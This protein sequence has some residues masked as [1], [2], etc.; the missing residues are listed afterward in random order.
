MNQKKILIV[1]RSFYPQISPRSFRTTELAKEFARQG[2]HVSVLTHPNKIEHASFKRDFNIY[3]ISLGSNQN[4]KFQLPGRSRYVTLINRA[5]QRV[6][7]ML[8]EYPDIILMFK[9][10]SALKKL[11]GFDLLISIAVP[12][13]VHWGVA[14]AWNRKK[15][16]AKTW[17]A[18]CGDPYMGSIHDSYRKLFY[19]K[20]FEKW[21]CRKANLIAVP[22]ISMKE[23]F[24]PEFRDKI[25]EIPQGFKF[26]DVRIYEGDVNN[27][28]PSFAFAGVFMSSTRNPTQLLECLIK[29][30][31]KFRFIAFTRTPEL[32][33]PYKPILKDKLEIRDFI[34]RL[35]LIHSLSK[36]DFLINIGYDP[37]HQA[38]SKLIDYFLSGRPVLSFNSNNV[39]TELIINFLNGNYSRSFKFDDM[40]LY[41]IENVCSRF[42]EYSK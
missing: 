12:H 10:K 18:D 32:L 1:S 25:I 28:V 19:F 40:E 13:P 5:I 23:N 38:P 29:I 7:L 24:Y 6:L 37:V 3:F 9:V 17:I 34:P 20:Y 22:K 14:W 33:L 15:N 41:K 31:R 11:S 8:I 21:F 4:P 2:H 39:D 27:E 26:E 16:I 30:D 42:L 36:M 35:E